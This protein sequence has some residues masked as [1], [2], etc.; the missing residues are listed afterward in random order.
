MRIVPDLPA[1][2]P[3]VLGNADELAQVFQN[4]LDNA[5]KYSRRGTTID[6]GAHPSPRFLP[7]A[8]P[9][10]R[11]APLAVTVRD[12]GQSITRDH[13]PLLTERFY[14]VD[15]AHS[16]ALFGTG[17]ILAIGNHI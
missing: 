6:V 17:L 9:G 13:L 12:H 5:I 14:R 16:R 4:L 11:P 7:G 10:E 15:A 8:R 2:L 3:R 1:G